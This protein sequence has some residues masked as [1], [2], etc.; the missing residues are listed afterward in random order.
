MTNPALSTSKEDITDAGNIENNG[1]V[2]ENDLM[3]E[4][5]Q[6]STLLSMPSRTLNYYFYDN[7]YY[8]IDFIINGGYINIKF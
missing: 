2:W 1:K 3:N 8:Y 7:Y 4:Q 6:M 5:D